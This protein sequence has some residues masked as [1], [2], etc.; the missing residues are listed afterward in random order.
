MRRWRLYPVCVLDWNDG[1]ES[2]TR[3]PLASI[4][5]SRR[6]APDEVGVDGTNGPALRRGS[7][8][9]LIGKEAQAA[10]TSG[11]SE[12]VQTTKMLR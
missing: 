6:L 8:G 2:A 5:E 4:A 9:R 10:A 12:G 3:Q 1:L 11:G 7:K